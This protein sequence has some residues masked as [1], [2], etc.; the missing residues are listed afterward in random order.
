MKKIVFISRDLLGVE[1]SG[2]QRNTY[3]ML[4]CLDKMIPQNTVELII[5]SWENDKYMFQNIKV[6]KCGKRYNKI[7]KI[8]TRIESYLYKNYY[9]WK[10]IRKTKS[11]SVDLLLLVPLYGCDVEMIYDCIPELFPS[12]YNTKVRIKARKKRIRHQKR[13]IKKAKLILTD[14]QS[15]K[16]DIKKFYETKDCDIKVIPCGW[17]HFITIE[18]DDEILHKLDLTPEKY[19]FALGSRLPHKNAKWIA[20]AAKKNPLYKFVLS[21]S[22]P[23]NQIYDFEGEALPNMIFAGRLSD[24]EVKALMRHCKA[25]IQPSLYEG[26]GIPPMEAMSVGANCIVSNVASL[27]EVYKNSVWYINPYDYDDIDLDKIMAKPKESNDII[28]NEYSW[29]RSASMLLDVLN[30]LG[31]RC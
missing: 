27:P 7:G 6:V 15:A 31:K 16:E 20:S 24:G 1:A 10:Y 4:K 11:I 3:E 19:F 29:Q 12:H 8:G 2:I 22:S 17:Q 9:T 13:A 21:G 28:L 5:P 25:F 18:E 23:K 14:S 26:F 30:E